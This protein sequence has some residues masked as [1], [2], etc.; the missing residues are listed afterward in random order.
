MAE[1]GGAEV[2]CRDLVMPVK[3]AAPFVSIQQA[4]S[5]PMFTRA[6]VAMLALVLSAMGV[7]MARRRNA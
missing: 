7:F 3:T 1:A 6:S 4:S 2:F 5:I